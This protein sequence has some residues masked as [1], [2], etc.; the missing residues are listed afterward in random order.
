VVRG[1]NPSSRQT[2]DEEV[3]NEDNDR[4]SYTP[5]FSSRRSEPELP[6]VSSSFDEDDD[7]LSYFQRLAE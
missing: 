2:F 5:D 3:S 1:Q 7:A 4:G 6:Q